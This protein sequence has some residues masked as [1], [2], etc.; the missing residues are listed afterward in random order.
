METK[1]D[2][3]LSEGKL[4]EVI[5]RLVQVESSTQLQGELLDNTRAVVDLLYKKVERF[6]RVS[7]DLQLGVYMTTQALEK[8][9]KKGVV[10]ENSEA[11]E[12]DDSESEE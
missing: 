7:E 6:E 11:D 9:T 12:E 3:S 4:A 2:E 8:L 5:S 10:S 1:I